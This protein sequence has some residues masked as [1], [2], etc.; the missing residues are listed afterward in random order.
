M[1]QIA[2]TIMECL[3]KIAPKTVCNDKA[4]STEWITNNI[5]NAILE[6]NKNYK[7][8]STILRMKT[9]QHTN[10]QETEYYLKSGMQKE[11]QTSK[12]LVIIRRLEQFS[13]HLKDM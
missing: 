13:G 5:K 2:L 3:D 10:W 9:D 7:N 8:G 6:L 11:I 4:Y 1:N 12:N